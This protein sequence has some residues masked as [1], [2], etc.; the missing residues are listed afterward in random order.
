M[1][2]L[3]RNEKEQQSDAWRAI[4]CAAS[5]PGKRL[6]AADLTKATEEPQKPKLE[7]VPATKAEAEAEVDAE[8]ESPSTQEGARRRK[9]RS[10]ATEP[11]SVE[12]EA[13]EEPLSKALV[14]LEAERRE[15][16]AQV[17]REFEH[18]REQVKGSAEREVAEARSAA[19]EA[20]AKEARAKEAAAREAAAREQAAREEARRAAEEKARKEEEARAAAEKKRV[21]EE[22][23][24]AE[25]AARAAE[26]EARAAA[27]E[28]QKL[29]EAKQTA[30][31]EAEA[32]E[33]IRRV[34]EQ[35]WHGKQLHAAGRWTEAAEVA[36]SVLAIKSAA[37]SP[38]T[39]PRPCLHHTRRVLAPSGTGSSTRCCGARYA[40]RGALWGR[41]PLTR[42]RSLDL[43][44]IR[45]SSRPRAPRRIRRIA[46]SAARE[47]SW[48]TRRRRPRQRR[49]RPRRRCWRRIHGWRCLRC[50]T[51]SSGAR[52]WRGRPCCAA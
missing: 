3:L 52:R 15:A 20:A 33:R 10:Q 26:E 24:E 49:R 43:H 34:V 40:D 36:E 17:R 48:A 13:E 32:E 4:C 39:R 44:P 38:P 28:A 9:R 31:A 27:E 45:R 7:I 23:R 18:R 14:R 51:G 5:R 1:W 41:E 12:V 47:R 25:E 29:E 35:C 11:A 46:C 21:E 6:S 2:T 37:P 19:R 42:R 30:L 8:A 50:A 22:A 16:V